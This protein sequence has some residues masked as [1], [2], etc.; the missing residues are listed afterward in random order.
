VE[1][2]DN[3][4][5]PGEDFRAGDI[6]ARRGTV[7]GPGL[8]ATLAAFGIS[9]VKVFP[10]PKVAVLSMGK[11]IVPWREAPAPGQIRDSN[12]ILLAFLA[13][14]DGAEVTAVE[15]ACRM[16]P[17]QLK[18]RLEKLL[19]RADVVL[20]TGG[21]AY[22]DH[23]QALAAI[24]LTGA[25]PLFW[26]VKI[27]PGSHSGAAVLNSRLII[28]L[29]GHPAACAVGYHLLVTP[30]LRILQGLAPEPVRITAVS[31]SALPKKGGP[32]RFVRGLAYWHENQWHVSIPPGQKSSMLRSLL[33]YNALL[34]IPAGSPPVEKGQTVSLILLPGCSL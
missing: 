24:R 3:L 22:G 32:R 18:G 15:T 10:K 19:E 8:A 14:R 26:E 29:P 34:D 23:D 16:E 25:R 6:I 30:V 7:I 11:N 1:P 28:A 17:V 2:G 21:A 27:K 12:G 33:N 9:Q 5:Q 4:K 31:D 13:R 20:T